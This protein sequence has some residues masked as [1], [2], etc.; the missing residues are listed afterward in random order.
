[1]L[2][3]LFTIGPITVYTFG[4]F[5]GI[6]VF[7][8]A[9]IIWRRLKELGIRE[10]KIIDEIIFC[11]FL[12]LFFSRVFFIIK[13]F[14]EFGLIFNRWILI[15]LF[16]G[17]SFWGWLIGIFFGLFLF[18]RWQKWDFWRI[19]D[20]VAFG[21]LPFLFL[22]QM[23]AFFDGSGVGKPTS[24]PWGIFFPGSMVRQ[25]PVSLIMAIFIFFIWLFLLQIER[26]WRTWSWYKSQKPGFITLS[27][28]GLLCLVNLPLAFLKENRLYF[29]LIDIFLSFGGVVLSATLIW[30]K[31]K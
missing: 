28:W 13:N 15:G 5:L 20:E 31:R 4:F 12:G 3:V 14:S 25:N 26:Q 6:G 1:M 29:F 17:L 7:F 22:F 30:L 8:T 2:P 23:G 24:L 9:F 10:E 11:Q 16:P 21:I 18:S 27:F 19:A